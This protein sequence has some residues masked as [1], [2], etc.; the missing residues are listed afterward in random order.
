MFFDK[1][2]IFDHDTMKTLL[3]LYLFINFNKLLKTGECT[4][5]R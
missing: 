2:Q 4:E 5:T 3:V 1:V